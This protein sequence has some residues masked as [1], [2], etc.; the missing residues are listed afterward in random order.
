MTRAAPQAERS[1]SYFGF[2]LSAVVIAASIFRSAADNRVRLV[3]LGLGPRSGLFLFCG[4]FAIDASSRD[5]GHRLRGLASGRTVPIDSRG[6]PVWDR[7]RPAGSEP[8]RRLTF[9]PTAVLREG[10]VA[11]V[12]LCK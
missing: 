8:E 4:L 1:D 11:R 10:F 7:D 12:R 5:Q 9:S 3:D 6:Q 2:A